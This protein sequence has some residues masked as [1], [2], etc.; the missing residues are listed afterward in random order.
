MNPV[1]HRA[2]HQAEAAG[3]R[4][5]VVLTQ[6]ELDAVD[7]RFH[8]FWLKPIIRQLAQRV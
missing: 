4:A 2:K 7:G 5:S 1:G 8:R 3:E 6:A